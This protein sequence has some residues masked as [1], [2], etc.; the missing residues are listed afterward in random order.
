[1][2]QASQDSQASSSSSYSLSASAASSES[3]ADRADSAT[4]ASFASAHLDEATRTV[5]RYQAHA[6][7]TADAPTRAR[8]LSIE[9]SD[10]I[11]GAGTMADM[12]AFTAHGVFGYAAM[13]CVCAQNTQGVTD[14]VNMEP[15]FL[16]AQLDSVA[17]DGRIDSM[18]IGMLGTSQIVDCV[19]D[20][21]QALLDD[22]ARRGLP[23]PWVVIDPVMYAKSGD[24]LLTPDAEEELRTILPLADIITPNVP[25]LAALVHADAAPTTWDGAVLMARRVAEELGVIVYAKAGMFAL[26]GA[27]NSDDSPA[28]A[29]PAPAGADAARTRGTGANPAPACD[30][31]LIIPAAVL[32]RLADAEKA[33]G[34]IVVNSAPAPTRTD[35]ASR[36]GTAADADT[37]TRVITLP[38][39]RVATVNVHGT[40]DS[41]SASLA[42]LRPQ[43]ASWEETARAAK[44]WMTGA[45]AAADGL[46]VGHGHGPIDFMWMAPPTARTFTDDYWTQVRGVRERIREMPF[47]QR[48][49]DGT[50][51][52][53]DF[54]FYLHQDDLYLTD[55]SSLLALASVRADTLH[56]RTFFAH[57]AAGGVDAE[58]SFHGQ[59]FVEHGFSPEPQT[60]STVTAAYIGH[61]HRVAD[62][63]SYAQLAA[64]VMPCFWLYGAIGLDIMKQ[65]ADR[66]L[67]LDSHPYGAWIR[68]YSD[69]SFN[70]SVAREL[71]VCNRLAREGS[72]ANYDAMMDAA[73]ISSEHEYLFFNQGIDRPA[74]VR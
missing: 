35:L 15:A 36:P 74:L 47:I 5:L 26:S 24:S 55:Y 73:L 8:V 23:R 33:T 6:D 51:D 31:A 13:T 41:L 17:D 45:I 54:S 25:E 46:H 65:A 12:K 66:R 71:A 64:V 48:M 29:G 11:G 38:G 58:V 42:A 10:P 16:R 69:T 21:L 1:M 57:A 62:S 72:R 67:D 34:G 53:L 68:Q 50:L 37:A 43:Y 19:R 52:L 70:T 32:D 27:E 7:A 14:I 2:A 40:G 9:G 3:C 49:L 4:A 39:R 56:D 20:W 61:E 63:G 30:D 44:D 28:V 60:M 22:Y 18:K 59:W